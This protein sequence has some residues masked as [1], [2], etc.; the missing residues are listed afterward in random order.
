MPL[1]TEH[2]PAHSNHF[3]CIT[4]HGFPKFSDIRVKYMNFINCLQLEQFTI[5]VYLQPT[6][7]VKCCV[8]KQKKKADPYPP[9]HRRLLCDW[10]SFGCGTAVSNPPL[11]AAPCGPQATA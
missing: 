10:I 5:T 2:N 3:M 1:F 8:Y 6:V 9:Y 4:P 11:P 7:A